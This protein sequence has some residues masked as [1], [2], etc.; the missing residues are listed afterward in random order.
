[1]ITDIFSGRPKIKEISVD[2]IKG[3]RLLT[4]KEAE[5]IGYDD[6]KAK[7]K[8]GIGLTTGLWDNAFYWL[9]DH[10]TYP[11]LFGVINPVGELTNT[12]N[13]AC[14]DVGVCPVLV[15]DSEAAELKIGDYF[16]FGG[17]VFRVVLKDLALCR[18]AFAAIPFNEN[19]PK[20]TNYEQSTIKRFIDR[21]FQDVKD[22]MRGQRSDSMIE[23]ENDLGF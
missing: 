4:Y 10:P 20:N 12:N 18:K 9:Q 19:D 3:A 11:V 2:N 23:D 15:I 8:R 13:G 21:W 6:L 16:E 1:M 22:E 7:A 17:M 14:E 5:R